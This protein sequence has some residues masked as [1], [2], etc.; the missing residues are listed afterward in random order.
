[1]AQPHPDLQEALDELDAIHIH[2]ARAERLRSLRARP[3][4][5]AAAAASVTGV[6]QSHW[7]DEPGAAPGRW[8]GLWLATAV[9]CAAVTVLE[10][11]GHQR[12]LPDLERTP[13]HRRTWQQ[14]TP[15][16]F[17]GAVLTWLVAVRLPG[18]CWLLPGLWQL[19]FGLG[20]FAA[21]RVLPRPTW[22]VGA[23]FLGSGTVCLWLGEAALRPL[24]MAGP[25]ALGLALLAAILHRSRER[26]L[27]V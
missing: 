4:G 15:S 11:L 6:L 3:V 20:C 2:L 8:L 25:F 24:A 5:F 26:P 19:L 14:F 23:L 22:S 16:L 21:W 7:L 1:M 9:V 10:M 27:G 17:V 12:Q 13:A 18:H